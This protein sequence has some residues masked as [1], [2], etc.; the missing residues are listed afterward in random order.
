MRC[1]YEGSF[2]AICRIGHDTDRHIVSQMRRHE[3]ICLRFDRGTLLLTGVAL[4]RLAEVSGPA[5]WIWDSRTD[6]LRCNPLLCGAEGFF[7]SPTVPSYSAFSIVKAVMLNP[8]STLI[9]E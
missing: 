5:V 4:G 1:S 7:N 8:E 6:A 3:P 9:S 2:G